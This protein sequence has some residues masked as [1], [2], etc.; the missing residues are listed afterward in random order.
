MSRRLL[1]K[2]L[3]FK[4]LVRFIEENVGCFLSRRGR[5]FRVR[6]ELVRWSVV[7]NYD[8]FEIRERGFGGNIEERSYYGTGCFLLCR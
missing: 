6:V 4:N 3:L 1:F 5:K 2:K 7:F 8:F